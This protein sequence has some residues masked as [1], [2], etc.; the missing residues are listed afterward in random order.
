MSRK[1]I[2][3]A[4]FIIVF[5]N[6]DAFSQTSLKDDVYQAYD[7]IVGRDNTSLYNGTE[8]T[9]LFLN[10]DGTYRYFNGFNYSKG[11]VTYNNQYYVNVSLKYD[12][13]EDNL[14]ARS[15][16]N[17]SIFNIKLIPEFVDSFSIYNRDFIRLTD[18]NLELS[19][20][21]FF[22]IAY[23]GSNLELY[24]KHTKKKKERAKKSGV[25]YKFKDDNFFVLKYAG[26]YAVVQ[27]IR[28]VRKTLPEKEDQIREFYKTYRS[29]YKSNREM[30]M[31]NLVKHLDGLN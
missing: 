14:L 30:F 16:D 19:G 3:F 6:L 29:L 27:S 18:T 9:D 31:I 2:L 7:N 12:L 4:F 26:K 21:G 15:D 8:F 22:E 25:E 1:T 20:N 5:L 11:S 17:L 23:P 10:T 13:M 24:I 28:D